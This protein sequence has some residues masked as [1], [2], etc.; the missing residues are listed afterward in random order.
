MAANRLNSGVVPGSWGN[1]VLGFREKIVGPI[2]D[3]AAHFLVTIVAISCIAGTE[4]ILDLYK[5]GS[6]DIPFVHI[7]LADWMFDMEVISATLINAIGIIKAVRV[8][9]SS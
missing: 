8:V 9:W 6:N 1:G 7:R 4:W 3:L 5:L 2:C